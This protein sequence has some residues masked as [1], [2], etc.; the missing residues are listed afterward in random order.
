M[1]NTEEEKKKALSIIVQSKGQLEASINKVEEHLDREEFEE[2]CDAMATCTTYL[3]KIQR[4]IKEVNFLPQLK[5]KDDGLP[6]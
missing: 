3:N 2:Y 6:F 5:D 4:R 1:L